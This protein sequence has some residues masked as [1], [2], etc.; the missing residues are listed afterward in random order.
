MVT[1]SGGEVKTTASGSGVSN[2]AIAT[3]S[4]SSASDSLIIVSGTGKVYTTGNNTANRAIDTYGSV[5][6]EGGEV[7]A[8]Y[9]SAI[10]AEGATSIV[11]VSGGTVTGP[12]KYDG[13]IL[14][15]IEMENNTPT[16]SP[17]VVV[18]GTGKVEATAAGGVAV[19]TYGSADVRGGEVKAQDGAALQAGG[20]ASVVTVSGGTVTNAGTSRAKPAI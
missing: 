16:A 9:T 19:S 3:S 8:A 17:N 15:V 20:A 2:M 10:L 4:G 18:S 5:L 12:G 14:P 6:V 1:V 13:N 11:T 7:S